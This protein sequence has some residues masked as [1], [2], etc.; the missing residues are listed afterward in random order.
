[1]DDVFR[2]L[3][4]ARR[5]LTATIFALAATILFSSLNVSPAAA[6]TGAGRQD[7]AT[8]SFLTVV[9]S[10]PV[11]GFTSAEVP[12]YLSAVMTDTALE[13]WTFGPVASDFAPPANRVEWSFRVDGADAAKP[14]APAAKRRFVAR[15]LL[16]IEARLYLNG[17]FQT[18]TT[19]QVDV[20]GGSEDQ[21]LAAT[22]RRVS[23][24]LLGAQG[25][26]QAIYGQ[27]SR[28]PL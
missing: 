16:L 4:F 24:S 10:G 3:W 15:Q 17:E 27:R 23:Q 18:V 5:S 6:Q 9:S 20:Y 11:P 28:R 25:A 19:N 13:N 2:W 1:M 22:I 8:A 26:Y 14:G 12:A 7:L 21:E